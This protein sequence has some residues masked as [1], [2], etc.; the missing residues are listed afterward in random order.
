MTVLRRPS[1][2]LRSL[3][4]KQI[5]MTHALDAALAE[6]AKLPPEDQ[7]ALAAILLEEIASEGRWSKS[8]AASQ[9]RLESLAAEALAEF[10]QGDT[11]PLQQLL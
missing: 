1:G 2:K 5:A 7:D 6:A 10:A 9:G 11:K 3:L 4:A 8:F